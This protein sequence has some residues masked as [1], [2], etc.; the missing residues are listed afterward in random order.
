VLDIIK[1][2]KVFD[3]A[4]IFYCSRRLHQKTKCLYYLQ[5]GYYENVYQDEV[6]CGMEEL[7][8]DIEIEA[9]EN[10]KF[11]CSFPVANTYYSY[12]I[13]RQ[14]ATKKRIE[15]ETYTQ[16]RIPGKGQSGD[17]AVI[18][19]DMKTVRQAKIKIDVLVDAARKKAPFTH[20]ISIPICA[21]DIQQ[22]FLQFKNQFLRQS[23]CSGVDEGMM[24]DGGALHHAGCP[25]VTHARRELFRKF[26]RL[27][28][29]QQFI[30]K[31]SAKSSQ[32][33]SEFRGIFT[34]HDI[35]SL[36]EVYAKIV[37]FC[38]QGS[39]RHATEAL[40]LSGV[41]YWVRSARFLYIFI[42]L[43]LTFHA[44][45]LSHSRRGRPS[46]K[47]GPTC[48]TFGA[49]PKQ[50]VRDLA[51]SPV[52]RIILSASQLGIRSH[53]VYGIARTNYYLIATA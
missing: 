35:C 8:M 28:D 25:W 44:T 5:K 37:K 21:N 1:R 38:R 41:A 6:D 33:S 22:R 23:G 10:G 46:R 43:V 51:D 7:D 34:K 18:G 17:V 12:L 52:G 50:I 40:P 48:Q 11:K 42:E 15:T 26:V 45:C 14:G 3:I 32:S 4:K 16:I 9:L 30:F 20:F 36:Y 19:K 27:D 29:D 24:F 13:G 39:V 53:H 31:P 2:I 49:S 47:D